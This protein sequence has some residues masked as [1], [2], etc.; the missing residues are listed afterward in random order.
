M[1]L[2][3]MRKKSYE[4]VRSFSPQVEPQS[5]DKRRRAHPWWK[6]TLLQKEKKFRIIVS[7]TLLLLHVLVSEGFGLRIISG[8]SI[9]FVKGEYVYLI[10]KK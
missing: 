4:D 6:E 5:E 7:E 8:K 10:K 9:W 1:E 2:Y 3:C